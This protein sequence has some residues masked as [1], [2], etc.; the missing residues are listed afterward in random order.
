MLPS[1][2]DDGQNRGIGD[3][4]AGGTGIK[5]RPAM[6]RG[7]VLLEC[8]HRPH[9][10]SDPN[11]VQGHAIIEHDLAQ[12]RVAV[13]RGKPVVDRHR[14]CCPENVDAKIVTRG[15]NGAGTIHSIKP[16]IAARHSG[17]KP[18]DAARD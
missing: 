11:I 17:R 2:V 13:P 8:R 9:E 4:G 3:A 7:I 6:R 18:Q 12:L 5:R 15:G 10:I 16:K 14:A 1:A